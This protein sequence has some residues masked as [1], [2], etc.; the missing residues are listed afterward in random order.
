MASNAVDL[1]TGLT[2]VFGTSAL[3]GQITAIKPPGATRGWEDTT[4]MAT[5]VARTCIPHDLM[6][7]G[8]LE[9]MMHLNPDTDP[10]TTF[11]GAA[12]VL[13]EVITITYFGPD[14]AAGATWVFTGFITEYDP[15]ET[16]VEGVMKV[17]VKV[18]VAGDV[19]VTADV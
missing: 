3:A 19:A 16:E 10:G 2:V 11:A 1:S 9:M 14:D 8:E 18:K 15:Q 4:H 6:E 17:R 12:G 7:W 5:T 13:T